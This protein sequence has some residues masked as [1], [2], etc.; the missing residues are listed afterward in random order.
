MNFLGLRRYLWVL[1]NNLGSPETVKV[2]GDGVSI[3]VFYFNSN[4]CFINSKFRRETGNNRI[5]FLESRMMGNYPVRFGKGFLTNSLIYFNL[6]GSIFYF[7][8]VIA[9]P[10]GIKIWATV[11]VYVELL[12]LKPKTNSKAEFT[13]DHSAYSDSAMI[14]GQQPALRRIMRTQADAMYNCWSKIDLTVIGRLRM[15]LNYQNSSNFGSD[16][17]SLWFQLSHRYLS[18]LMV[19]IYIKGYSKTK[20]LLIAFRTGYKRVSLFINSRVAYATG[21]VSFSTKTQKGD[22]RGFVVP[23]L[24]IG[25]G[26]KHFVG[27]VSKSNPIRSYVTSS[28]T[29]SL[30]PVMLFST[31]PAESCLKS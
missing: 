25:K 31:L 5:I 17:A 1:L 16:H 29:R 15:R 3:V 2:R 21:E 20:T 13:E 18:S 26:P 22:G 8:M 4:C 7:T 6:E 19:K 23:I 11:R 24:K 9:V 12:T 28:G 10:T 27:F 14:G 30:A